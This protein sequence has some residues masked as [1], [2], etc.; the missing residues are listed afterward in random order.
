MYEMA[1]S[2][3]DQYLNDTKKKVDEFSILIKAWQPVGSRTRNY[4]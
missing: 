1:E 3:I 4:L 2:V